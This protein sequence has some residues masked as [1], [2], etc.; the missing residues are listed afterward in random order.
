M[1]KLWEKTLDV[2]DEIETRKGEIEKIKNNKITKN[3]REKRK[4]ETITRLSLFFL[5]SSTHDS[6]I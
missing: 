4:N 6:S 2:L 5:C 3:T 1:I